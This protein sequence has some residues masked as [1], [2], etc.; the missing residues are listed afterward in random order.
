M[1]RAIAEGQS[2]LKQTLA[3]AA[4]SLSKGRILIQPTPPRRRRPA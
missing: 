1:D 3:G 2:R 4:I